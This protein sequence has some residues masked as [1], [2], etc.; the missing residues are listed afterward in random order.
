[1]AKHSDNTAA[2]RQ[3]SYPVTRGLCLFFGVFALLNV[4]SCL[5]GGVTAQNMN[6]WW[7][8]LSGLSLSYNGSSVHFGFIVEELAAIAM[9]VWAAKPHA[10]ALRRV[11]TC[12]LTGALAVF[13][14]LNTLT[15]WQTL[16]SG[17]L[18]SALPVPL[19]FCIAAF[20]VLITVRV[21]RSHPSGGAHPLSMGASVACA[22]AF[23]LAFPLLQI[24]FF[25]TTD[26]R[27]PAD[28]AVVF[29][30]RVYQDGTLSTALRERMDT[31]V[32]LYEQ[33]LIGKLIV[34]GGIEEGGA[35]EAQA[36]YNYALANGVPASALLIDRY[37]DSTEKSV[38]N[39][40]K[41]AS[42]YGFESII[43]TSSFY[44]LPRIKMLYNLSNVDVLTVPTV[45][46]ITG[47]GTLASIWR[48]I[49][50]WW[51]YW[52]KGSF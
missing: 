11:V 30:A 14:L 51:L 43:A 45:G 32:E 22:L 36:M 8:D 42:Q 7:I 12:I 15:Y 19:S 39:T 49:P 24:G 10:S 38:N 16:A 4:V 1:M 17:A 33:G 27:R 46:N 35:D 41:L 29:G 5:K 34:S 3:R 9:I 37:G 6:M 23:A 20:F 40:I 21:A 26:Y 2:P 31:A 25:G 18:Y 48:E 50:A 47:N 28:C 13:A 52:F 44:H